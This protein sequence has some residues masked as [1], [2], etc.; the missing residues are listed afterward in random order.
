MPSSEDKA[1]ERRGP[2]HDWMRFETEQGCRK[3]RERHREWQTASTSY[4]ALRWGK[5]RLST[6]AKSIGVGSCEGESEKWP[7]VNR[8]ALHRR[9]VGR[10]GY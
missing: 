2:E 1:R 4:L 3:S 10:S 5:K 9:D 6:G 7:L 8:D